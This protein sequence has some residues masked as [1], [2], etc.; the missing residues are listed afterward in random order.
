MVRFS[1]RDNGL[2]E[3]VMRLLEEARRGLDTLWRTETDAGEPLLLAL[4]PCTDEAGYSGYIQRIGMLMRERTGLDPEDAAWRV[5]YLVLDS[6]ASSGR[7]HR[8]LGDLARAR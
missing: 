1:F 5:D 8:F 6:A 3:E 2:A 4:L 7:L